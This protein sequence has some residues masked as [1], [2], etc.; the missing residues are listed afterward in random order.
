MPT[1]NFYIELIGKYPAAEHS[2]QYID[3]NY[4]E[5]QTGGNPMEL[6]DF[7]DLP[8]PADEFELQ[9]TRFQVSEEDYPYPIEWGEDFD[10]TQIYT[11]FE[12]KSGSYPFP[13]DFVAPEYGIYTLFQINHSYPFAGG[14]EPEP[15]DPEGVYSP[16]VMS[17]N[18]YNQPA[19]WKDKT[20]LSEELPDWKRLDPPFLRN[21]IKINI[22]DLNSRLTAAA[23]TPIIKDRDVYRQEYLDYYN[24]YFPS[25]S[26]I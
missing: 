5:R 10:F 21:G 16:M 25:E 17:S 6:V 2:V 18:F 11:P 12:I 8:H 23:K 20:P 1:N 26:Q 13:Q 9:Y 4:D 24:N 14:S 19:P 7:Y 3:A 15:F 22:R